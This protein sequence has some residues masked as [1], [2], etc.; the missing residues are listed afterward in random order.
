LHRSLPWSRRTG[1][2]ADD[3]GASA[4]VR[5]SKQTPLDSAQLAIWACLDNLVHSDGDRG[6]V[7]LAEG[8][9][10]SSPDA[11]FPAAVIAQ[12]CVVR[13]LLSAKVTGPGLRRNCHFVVRH[14]GNID[15][16]LES[17]SGRRLVAVVILGMGELCGGAQFFN[18]A[19][20]RLIMFATTIGIPH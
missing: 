2:V 14:P 20:E 7:G 18:M 5:R 11:T 8:R 10:D 13:P 4:V 19:V 6:L 3:A 12:C 1:V 17:S 15:R 16:I 9:L